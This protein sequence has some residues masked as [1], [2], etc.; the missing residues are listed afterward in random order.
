M[1][2]AVTKA[3]QPGG[4]LMPIS[5]HCTKHGGSSQPPAAHAAKQT[6]TRVATNAYATTA[7]HH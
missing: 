1:R 4:L 6:T 5:R 3:A 7:T 2:L